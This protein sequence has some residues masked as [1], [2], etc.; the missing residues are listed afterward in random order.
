MQATSTA[1]DRNQL[2]RYL[3]ALFGVVAL[4]CFYQPWV[5]GTL[6]AVGTSTLRGIDLA[7]GEAARLTDEATFGKSAPAAGQAGGASSAAGANTGGLTLPTRVP[8]IA[9]G[10][11]VGGLTLPTRVPTVAA[12]GGIGAPASAGGVGAA[13]AGAAGVAPGSNVG[14]LT[15]PTRVP[16]VAPGSTPVPVTG[17]A[18]G[19]GTLEIGRQVTSAEPDKLPQA[20]LYGI[21][22]A[23]AGVAIFCL[24][25]GR[26]ADAR[27]RRYGM[28]WTILLSVGGTLGAG[29]VL[30][31]IATAPGD[32]QLLAPGTA[33]SVQWGLWGAF[34]GFLLSAICLAVAWTA[35]TQ[36]RSALV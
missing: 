13:G 15:L 27:D 25:W 33:T 14:G 10:S 1:L 23:A 12:G 3:A 7:R 9:A 26:L 36:R 19:T 2:G 4:I 29:Y 34:M 18:P 6:P 5:S 31:K 30:Y 16:T 28:W 8:T 20:S 21:P 32:N 35:S 24:I 17:A 11:N 22:L